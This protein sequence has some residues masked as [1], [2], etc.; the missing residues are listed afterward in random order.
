MNPD[1]YAV[2]GHPISHSKSPRIHAEFAQQT[3]QN[4]SY[5]A[6]DI[7]PGCFVTD[8]D[9]FR[10]RGGRGLNVTVPY[11]EEAYRY[12][13]VLNPLAQRAGAVNTLEFDS[14]GQS[15]GH[16]TDGIGLVNDLTQNHGAHIEGQRVLLLG[17][18]GAAKG[19][20]EPLLNQQPQVLVIANRTE[21]K[22]AQLAAQF[23]EFGATRA[24]GLDVDEPFDLIIN[25]TSASLTNQGLDLSSQLLAERGWAY[26]MM[27]G[28]GDTPFSAW[29][30]QAGA[31]KVIDGLGMLVEQAAEAFYIWR[32]V[33]PDTGPVLAKLRKI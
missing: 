8:V 30:S 2:V 12:V 14:D 1:E 32:G 31:A 24:T 16:N 3:R 23:S 22:A 19:V 21:Q 13:D 25:A 11:K 15:I 10:A 4:L 18:G 6:I 26:D 33:R 7:E 17:A 20:V 9:S 5:G 28:K 27:Y 29:A